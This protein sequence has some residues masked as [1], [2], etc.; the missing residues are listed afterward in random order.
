MCELPLRLPNGSVRVSSPNQGTPD[1]PIVGANSI[2]LVL[3]VVDSS[4][5]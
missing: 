2:G 4:V 3:L 5:V 1:N